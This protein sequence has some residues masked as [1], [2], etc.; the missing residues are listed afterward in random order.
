MEEALVRGEDRESH[1]RHRRWDPILIVC[2]LLGLE[3]L[4]VTYAILKTK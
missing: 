3:H 4:P 2:D 1:R